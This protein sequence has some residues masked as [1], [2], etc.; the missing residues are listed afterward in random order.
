MTVIGLGMP[1]R[2]YTFS[3]LET[4]RLTQLAKALQLPLGVLVLSTVVISLPRFGF[5]VYS[6]AQEDNDVRVACK[7]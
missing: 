1:A 2:P 3:P 6:M 7:P 4:R 5:T